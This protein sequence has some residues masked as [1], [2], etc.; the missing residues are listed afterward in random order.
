MLRGRYFLLHVKKA[1]PP[2]PIHD[3]AFVPL[4]TV[5]SLIKRIQLIAMRKERCAHSMT[6]LL[7]SP[8]MPS[9]GETWAGVDWEVKEG[10]FIT[11]MRPVEPMNTQSPSENNSSI[12]NVLAQSRVVNKM[13]RLSKEWQGWLNHNHMPF[14]FWKLDTEAETESPN[15]D[16]FHQQRS[17][18]AMIKMMMFSSS[19]CPSNDV[20]SLF[21]QTTLTKCL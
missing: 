5:L 16:F 9:R 21:L 15:M 17:S 10:E 2:S 20:W 4:G 19:Q 7:P 18:Y 14:S 8:P 6:L 11:N 12:H 1:A 3:A 13:Q